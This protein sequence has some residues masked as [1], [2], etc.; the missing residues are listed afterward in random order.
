MSSL[1]SGDRRREEGRSGEPVAIRRGD[2]EVRSGVDTP[3]G[4]GSGNSR[5]RRGPLLRRRDALIPRRGPLLHRRD[6]LIPCRGPLRHRHE[7]L[8]PRGGP[9]L[10]RRDPLIPRRGPLLRRRDALIPRTEPLLHSHEALIPRGEPPSHWRRTI[11][12]PPP[13]L[14]APAAKRPRS[15]A[16]R[17]SSWARQLVTTE[18]RLSDAGEALSKTIGPSSARGGTLSDGEQR[19]TVTRRSVSRRERSALPLPSSAH[20]AW[21]SRS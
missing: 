13:S 21:S 6:P 11:F 9:L 20:L 8:I 5:K 18:E 3:H 12:A 10:H 7:A 14:F 17:S 2:I 19:A 1:R 16:E 15:A 4:H